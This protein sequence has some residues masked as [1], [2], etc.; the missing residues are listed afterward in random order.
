MM[1]LFVTV[2]VRTNGIYRS[3]SVNGKVVS[4]R[5]F[6]AKESELYT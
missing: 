1:L 6:E 4:G 5:T 2:L 3:V